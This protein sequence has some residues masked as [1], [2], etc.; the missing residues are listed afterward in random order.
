MVQSCDTI[1][2]LVFTHS[3]T[4]F[5]VHTRNRSNMQMQSKPLSPN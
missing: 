1:A 4:N 5:I 2:I 3:L